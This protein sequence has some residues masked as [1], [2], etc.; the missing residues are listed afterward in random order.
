MKT[1][2]ICSVSLLGLLAGGALAA[3][4]VMLLSGMDSDVSTLIKQMKHD[5]QLIPA[6]LRQLEAELYGFPQGG[7]PVA[8]R[9]GGINAGSATP[10]VFTAG[11]FDDTGSTVGKLNDVN[12]NTLNPQAGCTNDSYSTSMD[13]EDAFYSMTVVEGVLTADTRLTG[14]N[15]DTCIAILAA[16]GTTVKSINDDGEGA[17]WRSYLE[18]CLPAGTY[19]FVV[20]G[21]SAA[22]VGNYQLHMTFTESNCIPDAF[23]CPAGSIP[24]YESATDVCGD[25]SNALNCGDTMCGDITTDAD[26]DYYWIYI[27]A[28]NTSLTLNVYAND[29]P[30]RAPFGWGLDSYIRVLSAD[31]STVIAEDDDAGTGFDSFLMLECLPEGIYMVEVSDIW[32]TMGPYLLTASCGVC[33]WENNTAV[34]PGVLTTAGTFMNHVTEA[35]AFVTTVSLCDYCDI[36]HRLNAAGQPC[37]ANGFCYQPLN[38][39]EYWFNV[40]QPAIPTAGNCGYVLK[41]RT[42]PAYSQTCTPLIGVAQNGSLLGWFALDASAGLFPSVYNDPLTPGNTTFV[43]DA[44]AACCDLVHVSVWYDWFDNGCPPPVNADEQP[45]AFALAQNAPNPFNPT[46]SISFTLPEAGAASL[47]VF[48]TAGREVATLVNGMTERGQHSVSFDA[49]Q[50][51]TGVYF[52]TLQ[53]N[54]QSTTQKMV[55]V[56]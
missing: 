54:G 41:M 2:L 29:T 5:G 28:P 11:V 56:K 49:S 31:C 18:C 7:E 20:D 48:D 53:F 16:D 37:F 38:G 9:D 46:T 52:Y 35:N 13:A 42:A 40:Y 27:Q 15:Y 10:I 14:T 8:D 55:L 21:Y 3:E 17:P 51:S 45:A 26:A 22:D 19:Y 25:Y 44:P 33:C 6:D 4:N 12:N 1:K 47:K 50:L 34:N 32:G 39:G 23:A 43:V 36:L 30:G 24:H